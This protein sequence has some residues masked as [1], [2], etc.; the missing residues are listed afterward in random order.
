MLGSSSGDGM[1]PSWPNA[2]DSVAPDRL[3]CNWMGKSNARNKADRNACRLSA[4]HRPYSSVLGVGNGNGYLA[5][6]SPLG[7]V[8]IEEPRTGLGTSSACLKTD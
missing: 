5:G 3:F 8:K 7:E 1:P 4:D 6:I 2:R